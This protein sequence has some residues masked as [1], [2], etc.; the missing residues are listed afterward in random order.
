MEGFIFN[1]LAWVVWYLTILLLP[2]ITLSPP[3]VLCHSAA[4]S[5]NLLLFFF[6][7]C[8]CH[9]CPA[10]RVFSSRSFL[11]N[12]T[13]TLTLSLLWPPAL[14]PSC[15]SVKKFNIHMQS[16]LFLFP[17]LSF[18]IYS[19]SPPPE[20]NF[21]SASLFPQFY[22]PL[23]LTVVVIRCKEMHIILPELL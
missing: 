18:Y 21:A 9:L 2:L 8:C 4:H 13:L 1:I 6:V 16:S 23:L 14:T 5:F 15:C 3:R 12:F 19:M 7:S 20:G 10:I 17:L 22:K 11:P